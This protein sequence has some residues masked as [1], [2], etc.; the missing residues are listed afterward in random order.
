MASIH[1]DE[2]PTAIRPGERRNPSAR[3]T[4]AFAGLCLLPAVLLVWIAFLVWWVG[5]MLRLWG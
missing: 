3:E 5:W 4:I 1:N 2:Q